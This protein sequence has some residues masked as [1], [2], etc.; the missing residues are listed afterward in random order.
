MTPAERRRLVGVLGLLASDQD[1]ERAAAGL[2]ATRLL[3]SAG[4]TWDEIIPE[5]LRQVGEATPAPANWR[6]DLTLARGHV[7]FLR[8]WE[9]NFISGLATFTAPSRKQKTIL[10][11]IADS[12]RARGRA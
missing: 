1:G 6:A 5:K 8:A 12:L 11:E 10:H 4:V 3:R 9:Q 2:L 7:R